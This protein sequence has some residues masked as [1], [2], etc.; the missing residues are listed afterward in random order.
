M[1]DQVRAQRSRLYNYQVRKQQST[2]EWPLGACGR[3]RTEG[4]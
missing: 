3:G 1:S 4:S 2:T